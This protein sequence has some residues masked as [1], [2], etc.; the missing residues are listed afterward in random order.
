MELGAHLVKGGIF[1]Q[2]DPVSLLESTT[3]ADASISH[4]SFEKVKLIEL[5]L[6]HYQ[7][8]SSNDGQVLLISTFLHRKDLIRL[9]LHTLH[10]LNRDLINF[11][12]GG[13]VIHPELVEPSHHKGVELLEL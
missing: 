1:S 5:L 2:H 7:I 3:H 13:R 11:L 9:P 8:F 4:L 10:E 12:E 6:C